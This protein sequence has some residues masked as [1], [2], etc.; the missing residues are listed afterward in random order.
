MSLDPRKITGMPDANPLEGNEW[1][2]LV[3]HGVNKK[4]RVLE[5]QGPIGPDGK[6]A[7]ELAVIKGYSGTL[8]Q[9]LESLKDSLSI[10]K[11]TVLQLL[12]LKL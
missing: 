1:L 6:S 7:Y 4:I 12:F 2:E 9:W 10:T 8:T 5:L 11:A 3:Q